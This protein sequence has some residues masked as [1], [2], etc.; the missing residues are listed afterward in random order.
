MIGAS[1]GSWPRSTVISRIAFAIAD[2]EIEQDAASD[3]LDR[4]LKSLRQRGRAASASC[5][6][7]CT[8]SL[9]V[10]SPSSPSHAAASVTV[11]SVPPRP[12]AAGPGSLPALCGP[13]RRSPPMSIYA[14]EPPP[15]PIERTSTQLAWTG[16]CCDP[17]GR[18]QRGSPVNDQSGVEARP[19]HVGGDDAGS[20]SALASWAAA[21]APATGPE[22]IASKGRS[23]ASRIVIAPPPERMMYVAAEAV[24]RERVFEVPR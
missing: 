6:S 9:S 1:R 5:R 12:N 19:A 3:V 10:P 18:Q 4:L 17:A 14:I 8:L 20:R 13:T 11:G 15:A 24:R 7:S 16:I 2:E 22:E 21:S 23:S